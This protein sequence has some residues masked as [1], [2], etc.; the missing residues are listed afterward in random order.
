MARVSLNH[1]DERFNSLYRRF[2]KA[3]E[4]DNIMLDLREHEF[5][6][7]AAENRKRALARA[8]RRDAKRQADER[9]AIEEMR[10]GKPLHVR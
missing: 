3:V 7:S 1:P 5:F 2:R 10:R 9:I 4:R 6:T 8:K